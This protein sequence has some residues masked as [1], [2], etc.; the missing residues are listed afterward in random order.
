MDRCYGEKLIRLPLS[1]LYFS[2]T[3]GSPLSV[4]SAAVTAV[5]RHDWHHHTR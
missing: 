4:G 2:I 5:F 3:P 1:G